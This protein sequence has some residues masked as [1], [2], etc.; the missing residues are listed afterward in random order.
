[1]PR[2]LPRGNGDI[3]TAVVTLVDRLVPVVPVRRQPYLAREIAEVIAS[4]PSSLGNNM[5]LR[6]SIIRRGTATPGHVIDGLAAWVTVLFDLGN[7]RYDRRRALDLKATIPDDAVVRL[8]HALS[9][10]RNGCILAVPHVGSLELFVA[11]LKD[12]GFNIG[13]VY[14][15]GHKPTPTERWIF[16]GRGA[17]G[18]TPIAF[19]RR[20]TRAEISKILQSRG[21]VFMAVDV[22]PSA[23]YEGI[24]VKIHDAEFTYPPGPAL[25][26]QTGTLI[27]PSFASGRDAEGFSM[28]ILDPLEYRTRM[29][30]QDATVDLTQRLA[31]HLGGF[32]AEQPGAFWLWHPIPHDPFLAVAKR[33]RPDL[34]SSA[35]AGPPDDEAVAL[36]VEALCSTCGIAALAG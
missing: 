14:K 33:Q 25:Y 29:P 2:R 24:R 1:M 19:E 30:V 11:Y 21:V 9:R 12:R 16:E 28:N 10:S 8:A 27:L 5:F 18:A 32:T 7:L 3:E 20:N 26:A 17:T 6:Q 4:M 36:A 31:V 13:F 23:K 35:V 15:V 34:L 22:Y